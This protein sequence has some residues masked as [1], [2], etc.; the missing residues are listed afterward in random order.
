MDKYRQSFYEN[1]KNVFAQNVCSRTD[2]FDVCLSR[3]ALEETSHVY[4][5][6]IESEGKPVSNQKNS[7]R[8]WIFATLN[9]MRLSLIKFLNIDD[10]EF[11]QAYLFFWDKIERCNFFLN[12]IVETARRG[13]K[14]EGRLV[15]FLLNVKYKIIYFHH[16]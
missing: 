2:P 5:F 15:S 14:V 3:K 1:D 9:I 13:E 11:S 8:C 12:N 16:Y 6:K 7:G 10:F 4:E